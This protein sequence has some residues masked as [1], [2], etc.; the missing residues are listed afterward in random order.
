[1]A[2]I[3]IKGAKE[4]YG[5]ATELETAKNMAEAGRF[6]KIYKYA[7]DYGD[8]TTHTDYKQIRG[9]SDEEEFLQSRNV[10]N[11]VLIYDKNKQG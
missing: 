6:W 8:R 4:L 7:N 2:S 1:M 11:V 9:G 3:S 10:H 5:G